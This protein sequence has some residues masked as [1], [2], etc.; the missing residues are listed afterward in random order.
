MIRK[1]NPAIA[2]GDYHAVTV[3]GMKVGGFTSTYEGKTVLVLHN[4]GDSAKEI[5]ISQFGNFTELR[6]YIGMEDATL[7]GTTLTIG[8]Q[9]SVVLG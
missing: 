4:P 3:E 6:A 5:D 9:T 2:R 7:S 8:G 1:A